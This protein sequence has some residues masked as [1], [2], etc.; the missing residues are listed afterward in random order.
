MFLNSN[1]P[2]TLIYYFNVT[3]FKYFL[4]EYQLGFIL[5]YWWHFQYIV[6]LTKIEILAYFFYRMFSMLIFYIDY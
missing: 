5:F 2:T 1:Q 4:Y 6:D 3:F